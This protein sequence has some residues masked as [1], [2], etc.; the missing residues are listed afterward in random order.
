MNRPLLSMAVTLL[1]T[2]LHKV[3]PLWLG[4]SSVLA[5]PGAIVVA[6]AVLTMAPVE[7]IVTAAL[8]GLVVDGLG[9]MPLGVGSFSMVVVVLLARLALRFM[10]ETRGPPAAAFAG[11]F[12][13]MQALLVGAMLSAFAG[14][15]G[16]FDV[17]QAIGIGV[18]DGVL[19]LALFPIL[20]W[21][22]VLFGVE[23][24]GATLR[25]RLAARL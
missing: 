19:A 21:I 22:G 15:A 4:S 9:G 7:A 13:A 12:G 18:I 3:V 16:S 25:E 20:H 6:Y 11:G 14:R 8:C 2:A 24:K 1:L 17:V 23:E 5:T 10:T